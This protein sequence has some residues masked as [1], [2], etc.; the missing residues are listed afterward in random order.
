MKKTLISSLVA[1]ALGV[2]AANAGAQQA[3]ADQCSIV[4]NAANANGAKPVRVGPMNPVDGFPEWL[5]DS[6]GVK[7]QRC[8]NADVC[9][10]DPIVP[11]DA[12]SLQIGSGGEAFY[13]SA[14]AAV[15]NAAGTRIL[16]MG[17]AAETAF[18][19]NGPNGE[20]I[21]G[22]QL[23]FLRIRFVMGVPVD[24]TYTVKHPYGTDTFKVVAATGARDVFS[25]VDRGFAPNSTATGSVGPFLTSVSAPAGYLG[26]TNVADL[27]SGSPCGGDAPWNY[28]EVSGVDT[29]GRPV[30]FGTAAN[31]ELVLRT[32]VFNVQGKLY[33]GKTQTPLTS[34]RQTYSR[35]QTGDAQIDSFALSTA[36]ATVTV[37]DGPTIPL[38]TAKIGAAKT[39]DR[40]A[41]NA[42][43]AIDSLSVVVPAAGA[44]SLPPIVQLS[45][46][47]AGTDATTLNLKVTDFVDIAVADYDPVAKNLIVVAS[48]SDKRNVPALTLRD[49][50]TFTPGVPTLQVTT[51]AP[52]AFVQVDSAAGGSAIA[53]VRVVTAG[54]SMAPTDLALV[55]KTANSVTLH[56]SDNSTDEQGFKVYT[57]TKDAQGN[58][59]ARTQ[60]G[61]TTG[62]NVNSATV[63]GLTP[64]QTYTFQVD[65]F[66]LAGAQASGTLDVTTLVLPNAPINVAA[67]L[68]SNR[69]INITWTDN[70]SDED[71][72]VITRSA[73]GGANYVTV[74]TAA[75]GAQSAVDTSAANGTAYIYKVAAVRGLDKNNSV[76]LSFD[77]PALPNTAPG[78][79]TFTAA[80]TTSSQVK[81][82]SLLLPEHMMR[83]S[84]P[85]PFSVSTFP[86]LV[87]QTIL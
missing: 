26:D 83:P 8:L 45:A 14:D 44:A 52:P 79:P 56:W 11:T 75:A 4:G 3:P 25:T 46:S 68:G 10:F 64:G 37:T 41:L 43:D 51:A 59:T 31:P 76:A 28:V 20:P 27:V 73:D 87:Y 21:N 82:A 23:P 53:Q 61:S 55:S 65:S 40:T 6:N 32:D 67:A 12:F 72:F 39:L 84:L 74:A 80:S 5:T 58:I 18:L 16:T 62:P 13:W 63:T 78:R 38:G 54:P 30:N 77:T 19:E 42:T 86:S 24:G 1:S 15:S 71:G 34:T 36:T 57:V 66:N 50:G 60:V 7:V 48:S 49:L 70:S 2:L 85:G 81:V 35:S 29:L 69:A 22:S 47:D 33:D 9:F 17:M